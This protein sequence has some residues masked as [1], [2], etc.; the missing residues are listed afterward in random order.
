MNLKHFGSAGQC[1]ISWIHCGLGLEHTT[2][3]LC[4]E[5]VITSLSANDCYLKYHGSEKESTV[6]YE[7]QCFSVPNLFI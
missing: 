6:C 5:C 1:C 4:T 3:M 7:H 2:C